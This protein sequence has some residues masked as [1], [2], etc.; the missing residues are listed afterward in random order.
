[1]VRGP[2]ALLGATALA[3]TYFLIAG[4]LPDLGTGEGAVLVSGMVGVGVVSGVVLALVWAG[5]AIG[6]LLLVLAGSI[7]LVAGLD[8]ADV[9]PGAS[10]FEAL[11][12]GSLGIIV[13]RMLASPAVA[14]AVPLF[15]AG[16]DAWSVA[17]GPSSRLADG[18]PRG[19]AELSFDLPSWGG[20]L[21]GAASRLGITDAIF[22][23]MF[24]TWA[25]RLG[26]RRGMAAIGMVAGLLATVALSV[27][28]DR[29]IPALPLMAVGYWLP[30]LDR[31]GRLFR[32]SR[33]GYPQGMDLEEHTLEKAGERC[34]E[35]GAK[36][37]EQELRVVLESGGPTLC[38]VH[39][40]EQVPIGEGEA[41]EADP[42]V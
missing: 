3:L 32:W 1:M 28:T 9:G 37:T 12:A 31:L 5:D 27:T 17:S 34:E 30:N 26:L 21:G 29:A 7:L 35:C 39:A 10:T 4:E 16:I 33:S 40:A 38:A 19:A 8:A 23:A 13:G 2:A 42:P 24:A 36:L 20:S 41:A 11:A 18:E 22:L 6:P 14:L 15:V 25:G